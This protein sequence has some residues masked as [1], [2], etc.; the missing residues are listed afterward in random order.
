[1]FGLAFAFPLFFFA[2]WVGKMRLWEF[3]IVVIPMN[4][5]RRSAKHGR[6]LFVLFGCEADPL[7][8]LFQLEAALRPP[9]G[10]NKLFPL[11]HPACDDEC[12]KIN[13]RL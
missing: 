11:K 12:E 5:P 8:Q 6:W 7:R 9:F 3:L 2:S 10:R 1:M 13:R 4:I